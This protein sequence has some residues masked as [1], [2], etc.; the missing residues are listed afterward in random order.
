MQLACAQERCLKAIRFWTTLLLTGQPTSLLLAQLGLLSRPEE[1]GVRSSGVAGD[2]RK[3]FYP[4]IPDSVPGCLH[5]V[6]KRRPA[7]PAQ[8]ANRPG[9][10]RM[11]KVRRRLLT[12]EMTSISPGDSL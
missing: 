1:T 11:G 2:A 10:F 8:S 5:V 9:L 6:S 12:S 3:V 7:L 4:E